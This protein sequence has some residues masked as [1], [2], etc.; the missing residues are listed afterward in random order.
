MDSLRIDVFAGGDDATS[1]AT[2]LVRQLLSQIRVRSKQWWIG[3]SNYP[4]TGFLRHEFGINARGRPVE[5]P[6][7]NVSVRTVDGN[8]V[9]V[10]RELWD[11]AL[12]AVASGELVPLH[13]ELLLDARQ[14]CAIADY[15]R[16]VIDLS[17][18]CEQALDRAA[19]RLSRCTGRRYRRGRVLP[20][21]DFVARLERDLPRR[22]RRSFP[23][24]DPAAFRQIRSLWKARGNAAHSG[25]AWF[26]RDGSR[27]DVEEMAAKELLS[28]AEA[29][30]T[31]LDSLS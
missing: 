8:E 7:G 24:E 17:V 15:R 27:V 19:E 2:V 1:G 28:A 29:C 22:F 3:F 9:G 6:T 23:N 4:I 30:V 16:A 20:G 11:A 26:T 12:E 14:Y 25:E 10:T 21:Y 18:A 13:H 31:W 5:L